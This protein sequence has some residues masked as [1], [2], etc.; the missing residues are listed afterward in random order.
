MRSHWGLTAEKGAAMS[1]EQ[2]QLDEAAGGVWDFVS[3]DAAVASSQ[4]L[5]HADGARPSVLSS[6]RARGA[7]VA[8][9]AGCKVALIQ[10]DSTWVQ[11]QELW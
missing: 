7:L 3:P 6:L 1:R 8:L 2:L 5:V 9:A 11:L 4:V 10:V